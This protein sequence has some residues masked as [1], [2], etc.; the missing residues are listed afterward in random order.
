M[1]SLTQVA[2]L[3]GHL[4]RVWHVAWDPTGKYLATCGGDRSIRVWGPPQED[5]A[6]E[7]EWKL[8]ATL[9]DTQTRTVRS[10]EWSPCGE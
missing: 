2:V 9:E 10:C 6:G 1:P 7:G 5:A 3:K 4:D 8:L